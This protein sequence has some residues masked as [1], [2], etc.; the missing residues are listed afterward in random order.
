MN[1]RKRIKILIGE[2]E[3]IHNQLL[4]KHHIDYQFKNERMIQLI[5]STECGDLNML[6]FN[7]EETQCTQNRFN[8][9]L[10]RRIK[11]KI[12]PN[13]DLI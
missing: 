7:N 11:S 2:N 13:C 4:F 8:I 5:F 12:T 9:R 6:Q 10:K 1:L 3:Q